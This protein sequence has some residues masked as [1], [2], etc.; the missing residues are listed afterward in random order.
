MDGNEILIFKSAARY[1][2]YNK[3][4]SGRRSVV[5]VRDGCNINADISVLCGSLTA[6]RPL[7]LMDAA[8]RQGRCT[9]LPVSSYVTRDTY[10]N[11]S[12]CKIKGNEIKTEQGIVF[13]L[14]VTIYP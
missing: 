2:K 9:P 7:A 5:V 3:H 10:C 13:S 4:R 1:N 11:Q 8:F 14:K 6:L 12:T